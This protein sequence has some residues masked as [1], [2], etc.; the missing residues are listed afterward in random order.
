LPTYVD[1]IV[2]NLASP[3]DPLFDSMLKSETDD[4]GV[5]DIL[6]YTQRVAELAC[7]DLNY[8]E[9]NGYTGSAAFMRDMKSNPD[10]FVPDDPD[11]SYHYKL[12][13]DGDATSI[14]DC[15]I[16]L[17]TGLCTDFTYVVCDPVIALTD[18][19]QSQIIRNNP[20]IMC[21]SARLVNPWG[22]HIGGQ[23]HRG[24]TSS[25]FDENTKEGFLQM[26][27]KWGWQFV[28]NSIY[29]DYLYQ[30]DVTMVT[31]KTM[32]QKVAVIRNQ[33]CQD[34]FGYGN[35][36]YTSWNNI[37]GWMKP[38][39][40]L[41]NRDLDEKNI[42]FRANQRFYT[43]IDCAFQKLYLDPTVMGIPMAVIDPACTERKEAT[44][45]RD[46]Q[47]GYDDASGIMY[48]P[49]NWPAGYNG[50]FTLPDEL[51]NEY[52]NEDEARYKTACFD[53]MDW[54]PDRGWYKMGIQRLEHDE[55]PA[56]FDAHYRP[57]YGGEVIETTFGLSY[58]YGSSLSYSYVGGEEYITES[59]TVAKRLNECKHSEDLVETCGSEQR[60]IDDQSR[61]V[62][63]PIGVFIQC[64]N[65]DTDVNCEEYELA[66][67]EAF[68]CLD[69]ARD[70]GITGFMA[71]YK[72]ELVACRNTIA[73]TTA[74]ATVKQDCANKIANEYSGPASQLTH[75]KCC[76]LDLAK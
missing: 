60:T 9:A 21:P 67:D 44:F 46:A 47:H 16:Y 37:F 68:A 8:T 72:D 63:M 55:L 73:S 54:Q 69:F 25:Y 20:P 57:Q 19:S 58:S 45:A 7:A 43:E 53:A 74:D 24:H 76:Q 51:M 5:Y 6:A 18:V 30:P 35:Y 36:V 11:L 38:Q 62:Q 13:C 34:M 48:P 40:P 70:N 1:Y 33:A 64:C 23:E 59:W 41:F 28:C 32:M 22:K 26:F 4:T 75:A 61:T 56:N 3:P 39:Q 17:D 52:D 14:D 50:S 27:G 42:R 2:N 65:P 29:L 15:D 12:F 66:C 71:G 10:L 49:S 31:Y